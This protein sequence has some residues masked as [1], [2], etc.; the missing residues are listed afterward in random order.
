MTSPSE[1]C[2]AELDAA[3]KKDLFDHKRG[4]LGGSRGRL[5]KSP[6]LCTQLAVQQGC[7]QACHAPCESLG[8]FLP[9]PSST[10]P[11]NEQIKTGWDIPSQTK[12]SWTA[13]PVGNGYFLIPFAKRESLTHNGFVSKIITIFWKVLFS[14][15]LLLPSK[16]KI[17]KERLICQQKEVAR[18][19]W[20]ALGHRED[21]NCQAALCCLHQKYFFHML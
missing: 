21:R 19:V 17:K 2:S 12:A 20:A 4:F 1:I 10:A 3:G 14:I 9:T 6:I 8:A 13:I 5:H 7:L 11:W 18:I 16:L 15:F